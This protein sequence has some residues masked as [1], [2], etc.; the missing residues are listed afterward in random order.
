MFIDSTTLKRINIYA[1]YKGFSKLDT[2][3]IRARAGVIEIA[4]PAPPAD[5]SDETYYRTEQDDAPYVIFTKKSDEQLLALRV[6]KLKQI[7]DELT[8]NGGCLV[9]GK[10][11][12]TDVKSKQQQMALTM[13]GANLPLNLLW[14]TMDGSF[15]L[16]TQPLAQELFAAQMTREATIFGLCEAKQHDDTPINEGWPER[17][18]APE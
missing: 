5:Y 3:E 10:W 11:F 4:D 14:K 15:I 12:H 2:P 16:M 17:Y 6:S 8:E 18:E 13:A 7:R 9:Q 1:P